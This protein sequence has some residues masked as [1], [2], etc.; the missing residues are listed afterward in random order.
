MADFGLDKVFCPN[1]Q[2]VISQEPLGVRSR[3]FESPHSSMIPTNAAKMKKFWEVKVSSS[4]K[5]GWYNME[6]PIWFFTVKL[7]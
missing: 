5:T 1:F 2:I 7:T 3:S 4:N 6:L